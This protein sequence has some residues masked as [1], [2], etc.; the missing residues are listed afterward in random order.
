MERLEGLYPTRW[1]D[2][3]RLST[4][5]LGG[6]VF[7]DH[8]EAVTFQGQWTGTDTQINGGLGVP[9]FMV[10]AEFLQEVMP[11][12]MGHL[13]GLREDQQGQPSA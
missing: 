1:M 13:W 6:K 7:D 11:I 5:L 8:G 2:L 3:S 10:V 4:V 12:H 9:L